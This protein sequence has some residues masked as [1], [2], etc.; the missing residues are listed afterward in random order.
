M[1]IAGGGRHDVIQAMAAAAGLKGLA[2][3]SLDNEK[4][5]NTGDWLH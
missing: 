4:F 1:V 5:C 2:P 3:Q